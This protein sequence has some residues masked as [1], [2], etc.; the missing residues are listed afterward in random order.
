MTEV[1][2]PLQQSERVQQLFVQYGS[3]PA[4]AILA[5]MTLTLLVQSS[6]ASIAIVQ[7]LAMGGAFGNNWQV[8]L[9]VAIPFVLG[10]NIGTTITAQLA[11]IKAN[12]T[13][14]RA[15]WA[16]TMFNVFGTAVASPF[17][18]LGWYGAMVDVLSPWDL[19][20]STG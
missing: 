16:H 11:V 8:A 9:N 10:A 15:A 2:R 5:G 3:Q 12:R 14:R 4:F 6:S 7:L 13:A 20:Q 19:S 1:F 17:V 18:I